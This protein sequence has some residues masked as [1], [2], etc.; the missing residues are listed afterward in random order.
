MATD[1]TKAVSYL[2]VSG[3]G[4]VDGDGFPR[5]RDSIAKYAKGQKLV[6]VDEYRDEGVSG[7]TELD[8]RPGLAAMLD[9]IDSNGVRVVIVENASRLARDLMVQEILLAEFR[10]R[11]VVVIEAD[12]GNDL[13]VGSTDPTATLIRQVLGAVSQFEKSVLVLKLRAARQRTK[14][15]TG[16]CE[17][18]KAYGELPGETE[19]VERIRQLRRKPVLGDR[20]SFAAIAK[21]LNADGVPTRSGG[22]W[23]PSTIGQI[24]GRD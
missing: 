6:L 23:R 17:G 10:K 14:R 5:Q 22:Q 3:K 8:N 19:I 1:K 21:V 9:R 12:G 11:D 2:R 4:Q 7:T 18:R 20:L 13:T 16:K 24:L 15:T